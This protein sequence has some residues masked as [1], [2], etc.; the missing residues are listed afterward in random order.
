MLIFKLANLSCPIICFIKCHS[1]S[2]E[3]F[4]P[5]SY[6]K[7]SRNP[8]FQALAAFWSC[9]MF[10]FFFVRLMSPTALETLLS[11]WLATWGK[12][13]L[14]PSWWTMELMLTSPTSAAT[15]LCTWLPSPPTVPSVWSCW[16]TMGQMSTSRYEIQHNRSIT[17][18][19]SVVIRQFSD[20]FFTS[21]DRTEVNVNWVKI[22]IV[23]LVCIDNLY[24][25][26]RT[27][28]ISSSKL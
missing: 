3:V 26:F 18:F 5:H 27:F 14:L 21:S 11:T 23:F 20:H 28:S 1:G 2:R 17:L 19:C 24:L 8:S 16:S 13:Q 7:I 12:R 9:V 6:F 10:V 4:Y 22:K 25:H 15:P